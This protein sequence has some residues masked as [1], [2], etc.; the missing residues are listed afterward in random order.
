M[1][2]C[3]INLST[4]IFTFSLRGDEKA[5]LITSSY[6]DL[7]RNGIELRIFDDPTA[8]RERRAPLYDTRSDPTPRNPD[9]A[10]VAGIVMA[11]GDPFLHE[12]VDQT[13]AN[14]GGSQEFSYN[15]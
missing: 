5:R 7:S 8:D 2:T 11:P 1:V 9:L 10:R 15:I 4:P 13:L 6:M 12:V 3:N 14:F